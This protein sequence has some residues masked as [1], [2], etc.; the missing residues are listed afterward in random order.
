[1]IQVSTDN[2]R[3]AVDSPA[4]AILVSW[5]CPERNANQKKIHPMD[6]GAPWKEFG[7]GSVVVSVV[8]ALLLFLLTDNLPF[9]RK[10]EK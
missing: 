4:S 3:L 7:F 8:I 6:L 9:A 5:P 2:A 1:M 10:Y